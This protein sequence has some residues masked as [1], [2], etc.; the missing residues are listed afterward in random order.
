MF[1]KKNKSDISD[2]A[3]T[4][5]SNNKSKKKVN[6][7]KPKKPKKPKKSKNEAGEKAVEQSLSQLAKDLGIRISS[8]YGYYPEDVDPIIIELQRTVSELEKENKKLAEDAY[9]S[10]NKL[11]LANSELSQLRM[12]MALMEVPDLSTEEEFAMLGKIDSIT[13]NYDSAPISDI[14]QSMDTTTRKP[15]LKLKVKQ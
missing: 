1:F 2:D 8:P 15:A 4:N 13:G 14:K 5:E 3:K 12:Q 10:K 11:D 6:T 9:D 7:D